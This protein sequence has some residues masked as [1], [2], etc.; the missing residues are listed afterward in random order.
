SIRWAARCLDFPSR[1]GQV[2]FGIVQG[3]LDLDLRRMC[4]RE[5]VAMNFP[6]YAIGGLSVG[7]APADM[8]RTIEATAP[9]LPTDKPRYLMGV[10]TPVDLLE[11]VAL[12]IDMFDCVMP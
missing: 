9:H 4:A 5:L 2:L 11:S 1:S 6:G 7:E 10:G 12:G 3:G 8:Y